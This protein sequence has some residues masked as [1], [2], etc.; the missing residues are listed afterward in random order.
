MKKVLEKYPNIVYILFFLVLVIVF[1]MAHTTMGD[2]LFFQNIPMNQIFSYLGNRYHEWTSRLIIEFFLVS[3]LHIPKIFWCICQAFFVT[4]IAYCI[5]YLF[6]KHNLFTRIVSLLS[7]SIIS[8]SC[9]E[10]AGWYAT[11]LNY[12]WPLFFLLVSFIPIK[13]VFDGT[14]E[15]IYAYPL[16]IISALIATNQE[17]T[18]ALLFG[19]YLLFSLY[20][21]FKKQKV[22]FLN[23]QL[24]ISIVGLIFI[25][26]CPGN[27]V[28]MVQ[29]VVTWYPAYGSFSIFQKIIL[30][31]NSMISRLIVS[32]N[33]IFFVLALILPFIMYHEEKWIRWLSYLPVLLIGYFECF[34]VYLHRFF[35][36]LSIFYDTFY[37]FSQPIDEIHLLSIRNL[38]VTLIAFLVFG[39]ICLCLYQKF[40][41]TK[42]LKFFLPIL[43]LAGC[44]S[45]MILGMSPTVYASGFRTFTFFNYVVAILLV[46]LSCNLKNNSIIFYFLVIF[47]GL[48]V[49]NT[50]FML[51]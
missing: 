26:T 16:Y 13:H 33:S 24:L 38:S 36:N 40:K 31:I 23:F 45:V 51:L 2:D 4:G 48:Q 50:L 7:I 41:K 32:H 43:F 47:A 35:P 39:V 22:W 19:F 20:F 49:Y 28:R 34:A 37:D 42:E 11:T 1:Y 15:P 44:L 3:F 30:G 46:I 18:C 17:Q 6:T 12:I 14:K 9:V 29:E 27:N 5:S 10:E 21:F 25:F 8:F